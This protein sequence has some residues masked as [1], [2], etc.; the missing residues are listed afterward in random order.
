MERWSRSV[1][2]SLVA[3]G[4]K[5][6]T[7]YYCADVQSGFCRVSFLFLWDSVGC[8]GTIHSSLILLLL[9]YKIEI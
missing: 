4:F 2:G 9:D 5:G 8:F 1:P 7:Q 6:D 3:G